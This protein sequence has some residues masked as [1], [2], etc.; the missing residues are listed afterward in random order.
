VDVLYCRSALN[1]LL[2]V[3]NEVKSFSKRLYMSLTY[4]RSSKQATEHE[5]STIVNGWKRKIRLIHKRP[6][7]NNSNAKIS[8]I[9]EKQKASNIDGHS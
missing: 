5:A 9:T 3:N 4:K 8:E 2:T 7:Q 1:I 6:S